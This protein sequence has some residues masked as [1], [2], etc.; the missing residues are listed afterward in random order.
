M[1]NI[2]HLTAPAL[3]YFIEVS[4]CGSISLA[5]SHLNVATSAISR[6]ISGLEEQLG[7]PLFERRPRGMVL[8]A[9]GEMLAAYA[10]KVLLET[11]RVLAE[12]KD[13]E[14]LQQGKVSIA[15][16]EGFAM[17]YLP[18]CIAQF[19]R[20]YTQIQFKIDVYPPAHVSDAI[21]N[22]DADIGVTFSLNP[23]PDINVAFRQPAPILAIMAPNHPL[24]HK[25]SVS[26][27]QIAAYP[28]A[29]PYRDTTVR[30]LFDI[31]ASRQQLA[32]EPAFTGS[33]I[34]ALTQYT[35]H[36]GGISLFGE[37]SVRN[38]VKE[39]RLV[40]LPIRDRGMDIRNIE[41]QTLMG[42]TLPKAVDVFLGFLIQSLPGENEL[43]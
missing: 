23:S 20:Q 15:C 2:P 39:Q 27:S 42:R 3:R 13:L 5:S 10:R 25:K 21:R 34:A 11:D 14:G 31:C 29:L 22:G 6:Q 40:A 36:S 37:I 24:A 17:E 9:A 38:L 43:K 32:I 4:K 7:T 41:V 16:T 26:L 18:V 35:I 1:A 33:Y 30:Q 28:L 12:I 19:Q 8:S